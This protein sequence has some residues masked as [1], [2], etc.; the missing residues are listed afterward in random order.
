MNREHFLKTIG[1]GAASFLIGKRIPKAASHP[2][3]VSTW[4]SGKPVNAAAWDVLYQ[5][6]SA[7]DAVEAGAVWIE[8]TINCCVG[9]GGYPDR[10]G[11]VS[12]DASIM[13][14]EG[15]CGAVG[16]LQHFKNPISVARRIMETTPHI[17]LVGEGA[18][19]FALQNGFKETDQGLSEDAERV[20]REWLR[21][22]EYKPE[23]N[24]ENKLPDGTENHDTMALLALDQQLRLS[25]AVTTSGLAFKL[26]GRVGDSP[27]IGAGLYVNSAAGAA[28][29]TGVGE[30]AIRVAGAHLVTEFMLQGMSPQQACRKT[31]ERVVN[32]NRKKA[33]TFQLAFL[34]LSKHG[35]VGAY[36]VKK[37]FQYCIRTRDV[38]EIRNSESFFK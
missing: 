9:L 7:L 31:V 32:R 6:G 20:Y 17:L 12:L 29:S 25:G 38:D 14:H 15:N 36:A 37:G 13:D 10:D 8:N 23:A 28:C 19:K 35:E 5:N 26:H 1:L 21:K 11:R 33:E 27:I 4:N 30:E 24:I 3:V 22:S 18:R 2:V 34:A 16:F